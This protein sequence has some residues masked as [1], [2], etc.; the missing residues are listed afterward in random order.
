MLAHIGGLPLEEIAT[1]AA[2][3]GAGLL[4]ARSWLILHLR[5][6]QKAGNDR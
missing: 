2:G 4:V 5:R 3:L 1:S 6:R